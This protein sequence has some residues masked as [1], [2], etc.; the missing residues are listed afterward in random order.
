MNVVILTSGPRGAGKS[1][2]SRMVCDQNSEIKLA[3]RDDLLMRLYGKTSFCPYTENPW[4]VIDILYKD[5][6]R[7]FRLGRREKRKN[8]VVIFDCWNGWTSD[9][10]EILSRLRTL[11]AH[12]VICWKFV[13]PIDFCEVWYKEREGDSWYSGR[14]Y[15]LYHNSSKNIDKDGFDAVYEINPTQLSIPGIPLVKLL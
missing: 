8:S 12:R 6:K 4:G 5:I 15:W 14:N 9:R 10:D 7:F 3:S 2:Y 1:V 13:T 11:G